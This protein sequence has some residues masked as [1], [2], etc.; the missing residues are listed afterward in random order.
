MITFLLKSG[1]IMSL[2]SSYAFADTVLEAATDE[3]RAAANAQAHQDSVDQHRQHT[4]GGQ[5]GRAASTYYYNADKSKIEV[6]YGKWQITIQTPQ[7]KT[8]SLEIS[9]TVTDKNFGYAGWDSKRSMSCFYEPNI[10]HSIYNY[11]CLHVTDATTGIAQRYLFNVNG[12]TLTGKYHEGT[13]ADFITKLNANQLYNLSG[14]SQNSSEPYYNDANG[15]LIIP[16]VSAFGKRY[17]VIMK[18]E[19]NGQ[20]SLK[21]ATP[22]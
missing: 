15:E 1:L 16:K 12:T 3:Q 6:L 9:A 7:I 2:F 10:L 11:E 8:E 5:F 22:L 13:A 20:F 4:V 17:H 14:S 19:K 18:Q 21:S